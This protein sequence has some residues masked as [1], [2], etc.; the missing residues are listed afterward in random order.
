MSGESYG[1][2]YLLAAGHP[3]FVIVLPQTTPADCCGICGR[4]FTLERS[5]CFIQ[6]NKTWNRAD[7]SPSSLAKYMIKIPNSSKK[8][9]NP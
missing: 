2:S 4:V 6:L 7:T 3:L 5:S 9:E 8:V 1:V